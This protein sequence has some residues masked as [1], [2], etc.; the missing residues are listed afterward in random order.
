MWHSPGAN[1]GMQPFPEQGRIHFSHKRVTC[2][3]VAP[4]FCESLKFAHARSS[5]VLY[6]TSVKVGKTETVS[7]T[8]RVKYHE[9]RVS[10]RITKIDK[11]AASS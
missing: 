2:R 8:T 6:S 9:K 4:V 10:A 7:K 5:A 3:G 1:K 11:A